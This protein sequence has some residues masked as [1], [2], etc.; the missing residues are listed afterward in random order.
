MV[1]E[2]GGMMR[3]A[4]PE[5]C[6]VNAHSKARTNVR[7]NA[8]NERIQDQGSN[9]LVPNAP[10]AVDKPVIRRRF[11][12]MYGSP[13]MYWRVSHP[14]LPAYFGHALHLYTFDDAI[15]YANAICAEAV[16]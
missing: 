16:S 10:G 11:S 12:F 9:R 14:S 13:G 8:T 15:E 4:C 6:P 3:Q 2:G 5:Q 7:T 1:K